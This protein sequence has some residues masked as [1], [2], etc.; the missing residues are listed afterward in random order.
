MSNVWFTSDTH[1]SGYDTLLRE[2][3]PFASTKDFGDYVINKW[4]SQISKCDTIYHLGDFTNY[5]K[6]N[7]ILW[8]EGLSIV[9]KINCKVILVIGNNEERII[10]DVFNNSFDEFCIWC[11]NI[12]FYD[13]I[14]DLF[15][16]ID[17]KQFYLNHYPHRNK[18]GFINLFGHT[19]R[20]SGLYKPFGLNVCCDLNH[21]G[22]FSKEEIFRLL[23]NKEQYWDN[24]I[25]TNCM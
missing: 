4:N 7:K 5:N 13:V 16:N 6:D 25:D 12:G 3:R 24:D 22:L 20:A 18:S 15:I 17:D 10:T 19:H 2:N 14:T 9:C 23:K 1:F 11:K 8:K 21:F